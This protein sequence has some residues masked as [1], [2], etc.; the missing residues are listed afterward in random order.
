MGRVHYLRAAGSAPISRLTEH[1]DVT[2]EFVGA[3]SNGLAERILIFR[4]I[5]QVSG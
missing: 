4:L 1:L 2:G 5:S 3:T